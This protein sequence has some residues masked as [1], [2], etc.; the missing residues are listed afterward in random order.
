M[1]ETIDEQ[2]SVGFLYNHIKHSGA[3]SV[4]YWRGR[5]YTLSQ[6]GLHYTEHEGRV[7]FHIFSATDGTTCFRLKFDTETL[8]WK[9][10]EVADGSNE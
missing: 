4:L 5:R 6:I 9:L 8:A 2:V 3:P 7:L 1:T 10:L